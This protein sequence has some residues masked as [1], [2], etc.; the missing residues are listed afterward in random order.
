MHCRHEIFPRRTKVVGGQRALSQTGG[1]SGLE[2]GREQVSKLPYALR[3]VAQLHILVGVAAE[4]PFE[5]EIQPMASGA[6][7]LLHQTLP[8][9]LIRLAILFRDHEGRI[10]TEPR[11][12]VLFFGEL[13][14]PNVRLALKSGR[15]QLGVGT[16]V[17]SR[18]CRRSPCPA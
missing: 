4:L 3:S 16:A 13:P 7:G 15:T 8:L 17:L 2:T 12:A 18:G 11:P 10:K 14:G 1:A 6:G 5:N 9:P